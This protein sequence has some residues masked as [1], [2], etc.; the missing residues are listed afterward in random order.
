MSTIKH[1]LALA[2]AT[3][4][5]VFSFGATAS[6]STNG[7][8]VASYQPDTVQF[9]NSY[10]QAGD[11]F[12]LVKVGGAGGGEGSHYVNPKAYNQ[13]QNA[14]KVGLDTG[15]YFFS[16]FGASVPEAQRQAQ[17]T[18]ADA[19]RAG[20]AKGSYLASDYEAGATWDKAGNTTAILA[21]MDALAEAGYKPLLYSGA[22]YMRQYI[23]LDRINARYPNRLWVANYKT[24][25]HQAGPD[26]G[27]MPVMSNIFMWQYADNHWGVD[28]NV[29]MQGRLDDGKPATV[30]ATPAP[31]APAKPKANTVSF[32]GT[33]VIDKWVRYQGRLYFVNKDMGK[34][35]PMDYNQYIPVG[36]VT[37]TDRYG[38]TLANQYAQGN[39][40]RMEFGR[41]EGHY[42]VL[43]RSGKYI[44]VSINGEPVW[45]DA[46]YT[47]TD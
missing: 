30:P 19:Q 4:V 32:K 29:L 23:D 9:F 16:Q 17:L 20:L 13:V 31:V 8:D 38:N 46:S 1:K 45:L 47:T 34:P 26:F 37:L 28:G 14:D 24:T 6:A 33:F 39:N 22:Y 3:A 10:K 5:A 18:I 36:A 27:W 44:Q 41:L 11:T 25:A 7:I 43:Q 12:V 2:V 21:Y 40:G 15:G 42:T 35:A